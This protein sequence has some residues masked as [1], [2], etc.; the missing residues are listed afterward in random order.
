MSTTN[1]S[2]QMHAMLFSLFFLLNIGKQSCLKAEQLSSFNPEEEKWSLFTSVFNSFYIKILFFL[3]KTSDIY[4]ECVCMCVC[5]CVCV[6]V[7]TCEWVLGVKNA[8]KYQEKIK[9]IHY[10]ATQKKTLLTFWVF[11]MQCFSMIF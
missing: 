2:W 6:C 3:L 5:V 8:D 9:S 4:G 1:L 10:S 7:P 11:S